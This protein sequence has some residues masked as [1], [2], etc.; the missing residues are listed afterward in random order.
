MQHREAP[1]PAVQE[2]LNDPLIP[3]AKA[4]L[5]LGVTG[6]KVRYLITSH[7][8]TAHKVG[9]DYRI[10]VSAITGYLA[11]HCNATE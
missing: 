5:I 11:T 10:R 4:A 7:E 6:R 2:A 8:L 1:I 9:H 3:T